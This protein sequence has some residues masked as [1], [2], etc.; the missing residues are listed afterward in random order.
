MRVFLL[1]AANPSVAE[2]HVVP[3]VPPEAVKTARGAALS[4]LSYRKVAPSTPNQ[5]TQ[6]NIAG[7][8]FCGTLEGYAPLVEQAPFEILECVEKQ[9]HSPGGTPDNDQNTR[10]VL[11][12]GFTYPERC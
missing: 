9:S 6:T 11:A 1:S 5:W 12:S 4:K 7:K 10:T 3:Y 2:P 8:S